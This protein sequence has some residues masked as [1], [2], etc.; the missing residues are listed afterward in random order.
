LSQGSLPETIK[1]TAADVG[2]LA[3]LQAELAKERIQ[4]QAKRKAIFAGMVG[5]GGFFLLYALLFLLATAAAG[6]AIVLPLW[7]SLLI[8]G[9]ATLFLGALLA[10]IGAMGLRGSGKSAAEEKA[11]EEVPWLQ[12]K[13]S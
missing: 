10:G 6:L 5:G 8:V 3:K 12:A 2:R 7:L 1:R 11:T 13:S 9:G 4:H